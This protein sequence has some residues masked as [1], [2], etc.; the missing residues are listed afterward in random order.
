MVALEEIGGTA[1]GGPGKVW[2]FH[3]PDPTNHGPAVLA[4]AVYPVNNVKA[5]A[6][7]GYVHFSNGRLYANVVNNGILG[8]T[9]DSIALAA[10][11]ITKDLPPTN[12]VAVASAAHFEVTAV[13]DV[14]NYQW[15]SNNVAV[16]GA[17]NYY[18]DIPNVQASVAGS[19]FKVVA[20]N[21]A[22]S[23]TSANSVLAV[24]DPGSLYHLQ[25]RWSWNPGEGAALRRNARWRTTRFPINCL[26]LRVSPV[27]SRFRLLIQTAA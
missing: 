25:T 19:V 13:Y 26:W 9:V 10:P 11:T 14:T 16:S 22:G 1:N 5:T 20:F 2:L 18:I 23:A 4:S 6:P 27:R 12:R 21:S 24:V 8:Q 17:N 3:I 7:M 15:Y